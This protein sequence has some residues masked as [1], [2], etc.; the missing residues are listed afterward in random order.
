MGSTYT[1]DKRK[2]NLKEWLP[3]SLPLL[4]THM[5]DARTDATGRNT[6][7]FIP[8]EIIAMPPK[9]GAGESRNWKSPVLCTSDSSCYLSLAPHG[10]LCPL[11]GNLAVSGSVPGWTSNLFLSVNNNYWLEL[12]SKELEL[13]LVKGH[14]YNDTALKSMKSTDLHSWAEGW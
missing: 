11:R 14:C 12:M 2:L 13:S 7:N 10:S 8:N 5:Q 4:L 9:G 6:L 1:S 3:N